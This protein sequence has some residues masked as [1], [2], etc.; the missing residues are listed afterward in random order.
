MVWWQVGTSFCWFWGVTFWMFF[1]L[2]CWHFQVATHSTRGVSKVGASCG[3][4]SRLRRVRGQ[5]SMQ[6]IRRIQSL[7]VWLFWYDKDLQKFQKAKNSKD[8]HGFQVNQTRP[9]WQMPTGISETPSP[10]G[11]EFTVGECAAW[12]PRDWRG[13]PSTLWIPCLKT[14]CGNML[15]LDTAIE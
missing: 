11:S 5:W 7:A 9:S 8:R 12:V 4:M 1:W 3:H 2:S 14:C 6:P 10:M 15:D 13:A